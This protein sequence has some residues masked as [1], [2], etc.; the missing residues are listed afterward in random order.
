MLIVLQYVA[1]FICGIIAGM[2]IAR[3]IACKIGSIVISESENAVYLAFNKGFSPDDLKNH[4]TVI[5][6]VITQ[7]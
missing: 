6:H 4:E 3:I 2:I 5:M 7:K 1:T